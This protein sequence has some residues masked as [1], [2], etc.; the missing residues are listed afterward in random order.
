MLLGI[1]LR[2]MGL[3]F[4]LVGEFCF[5]VGRNPSVVVAYTFAATH[6]PHY[7]PGSAANAGVCVA[8]ALLALALRFVHIRENENLE[9]A[10]RDD[11]IQLDIVGGD[12]RARGFRY[13]Y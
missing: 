5:L 4:I 12:R 11:V 2:F 1:A 8:V 10:E 7:T 9:A 13:V 3:I 6:D